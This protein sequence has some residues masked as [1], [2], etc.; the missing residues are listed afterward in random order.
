VPRHSTA[1]DAKP[2]TA[3]PAAAASFYKLEHPSLRETL[4]LFPSRIASLASSPG[5]TLSSSRS[6]IYPDLPPSDIA[7]TRPSLPGCRITLP[8]R[9]RTW[10]LMVEH[11][12]RQRRL[13][14]SLL[15]PNPIDITTV[16]LLVF[17]IMF[18]SSPFPFSLTESTRTSPFVH[19]TRSTSLCPTAFNHTFYRAC[20]SARPASLSTSPFLYLY[21]HPIPFSFGFPSSNVHSLY[22]LS[23]DFCIYNFVCF[24]RLACQVCFVV[25]MLSPILYLESSGI[26]LNT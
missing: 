17:A 9:S 4:R 16:Y 3:V 25:Y 8:W 7:A 22:G 19:G 20:I 24:L 13:D 14:V 12:L 5:I 6:I 2:A 11:A 21:T 23:W 18:G 26:Q 1:Q 10:L 15:P